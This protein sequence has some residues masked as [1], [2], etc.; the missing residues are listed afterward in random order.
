[1]EPGQPTAMPSRFHAIIDEHSEIPF[2]PGS[3]QHAAAA[4]TWPGSSWGTEA[5]RLTAGILNTIN[6][7]GWLCGNP[8][9]VESPGLMTGLAGIGY[10]LLRCAEPARVPSVLSLAPPFGFAR[11]ARIMAHGCNARPASE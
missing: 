2:V 3:Q 8:L 6:R 5:E 4:Q 1:M 10:G 11:D 7:D 9:A